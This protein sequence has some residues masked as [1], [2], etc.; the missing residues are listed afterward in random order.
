MVKAICS[1]TLKRKNFIKREENFKCRFCGFLVK[2][3]GFTN[4]CPKCLYSLHVD[5]DLPGDR[6]STCLG[7]MKP[8]GIDKKRGK[9]II[10]HE[11]TECGKRF[12][13]KVSVEDNFNKLIKLSGGLI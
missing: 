6:S 10:I 13:C 2:G 12:K 8:I 7:L 4:H 1:N 3:D 11:C 5:K 9:Y